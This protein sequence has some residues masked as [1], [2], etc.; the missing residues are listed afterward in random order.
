MYGYVRSSASNKKP[1]NY[2]REQFLPQL[3]P[4]EP[5]QT[6]IYRYIESAFRL[7][8]LYKIYIQTCSLADEKGSARPVIIQKCTKC[9]LFKWPVSYALSLHLSRVRLI[10]LNDFARVQFVL[11]SCG[12]IFQ[13]DYFY[14]VPYECHGKMPSIHR[15]LCISKN[16]RSYLFQSSLERISFHLMLSIYTKLI[17]FSKF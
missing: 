7:L 17:Q 16:F 2:C 15:L 14:S 11:P 5:H 6:D 13:S 12:T 4:S 8:S 10:G 1:A 9:K 3:Q